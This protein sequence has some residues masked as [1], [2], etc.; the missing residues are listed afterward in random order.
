MV[1]KKA[2]ISI[3]QTLFEEME[4]MAHEMAV[5]RSF[6]F[7]LAAREFLQQHKNEKLLQAINAAYDGPPD[8]DEEQHMAQMK[9]LQRR[10]VEDQW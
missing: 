1:N 3:E 9:G 6:L 2:A 10:L 8:H 7:S 4:A 5:S